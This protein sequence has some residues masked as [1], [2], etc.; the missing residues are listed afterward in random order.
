MYAFKRCLYVCMHRSE[1]VSLLMFLSTTLFVL[2]VVCLMVLVNCSLNAFAI[3]L[4]L[5][6]IG[7]FVAEGDSVVVCLG[8]FFCFL[9]H[10]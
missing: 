9:A 3:C 10:I 5:V 1:Y 2:L 6:A 8:S 7:Y 4:C